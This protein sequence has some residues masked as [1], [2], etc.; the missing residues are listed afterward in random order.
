MRIFFR[1]QSLPVA[2]LVHHCA[3]VVLFTSDDG[4]VDGKNYVEYACIR[5]D[6]EDATNEEKATS[7]AKNKLTVHKS[8]DFAGWDAFKEINKK[9]LDYEIDF[10]RIRNKITFKTENAGLSIECMTTVPKGADNVYVAI[11]GDLCVLMDIRFR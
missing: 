5:M 11:S 6:G 3:C 10:S 7:S 1:S 8:D 9:G 2:C 4:N